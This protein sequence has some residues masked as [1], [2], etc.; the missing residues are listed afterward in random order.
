MSKKLSELS[1]KV[2]SLSADDLLYVSVSGQSKSIRASVLEA[3][4][5]AYADQ[6]KSEVISEVEALDLALDAEIASR[7]TGDN[8]TLNAAMAYTDSAI[9]NVSAG[10]SVAPTGVIQMFGGS[11]APSGWLLCNGSAVSRS[12]YSFLFDVIGETFGAGDGSTTFNLPDPD[13]NVGIK[14][15]IKT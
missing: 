7:Q 1:E 15:I 12:S 6:K 13:G 10:G 4:L 2:T 5:K 9:S 3:P 8:N 11:T 14:F